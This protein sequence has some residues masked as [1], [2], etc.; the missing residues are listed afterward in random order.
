MGRIQIRVFK[1]QGKHI[2]QS[3]ENLK[4]SAIWGYLL[5]YRFVRIS[6][7]AKDHFDDQSVYSAFTFVFGDRVVLHG[8]DTECSHDDGASDFSWS[9]R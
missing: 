2:L 9:G 1:D 4:M 5:V 7:I 6:A 3:I 8:L